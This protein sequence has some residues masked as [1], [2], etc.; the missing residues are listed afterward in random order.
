MSG[1]PFHHVWNKEDANQAPP[2]PSNPSTSP[3]T[4]DTTTSPPPLQQEQQHPPPTE[5]PLGFGGSKQGPKLSNLHCIVCKCLYYDCTTSNC[6]H[7]FC[8]ECATKFSDCPV[9]GHDITSWTPDPDTQA[10]VDAYI[11]AHANTH[12]IWDLEDRNITSTSSN[13]VRNTEEKQQQQQQQQ[14]EEEGDQPGEN[15]NNKGRA[16]FM[17]Q[18]GLRAMRG[19]NIQSATARLTECRDIL[20]LKTSRQDEEKNEEKY[21]DDLIK[22]GAV[23]GCLGDC[24]RYQGDLSN[25]LTYY[26]NSAQYL[27]FLLK[28]YDSDGNDGGGGKDGDAVVGTGRKVMSEEEGEALHA[29]SVAWNKAGEALHLSNDLGGAVERYK[30]GAALRLQLVE[31]LNNDSS[32]KEEGVAVAAVDATV[33]CIKCGDAYTKL[34]DVDKGREWME[35]GRGM[36]MKHVQ[37]ELIKENKGALMKYQQVLTLLND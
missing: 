12:S 24:A 23:C 29:L 22:L 7:R 20:V 32:K 36:L 3:P 1:C 4:L 9:C 11:D 33:A 34:G 14:Q 8:R 21:R 13:A 19:G 25:A 2:P 26:E 30:Q 5:C 15:N 10:T 31:R 16:E 18:L 17:L 37:V 6:R 28:R 27:E 35:R